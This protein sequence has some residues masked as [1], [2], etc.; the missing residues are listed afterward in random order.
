M[1][2]CEQCSFKTSQKKTLENHVKVKHE[3]TSFRETI[4]SFINR[5]ELEHLSKGYKEYF[6]RHGFNREEAGHM[7]KMIQRHGAYYIWRVVE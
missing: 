6:K 1:L 2:T 5:L 7:E 3:D 4:S